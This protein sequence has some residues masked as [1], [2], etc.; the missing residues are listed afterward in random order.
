LNT[1][2]LSPWF[3][4][5]LLLTAGCGAQKGIGQAGSCQAASPD[6]G[7]SA[8]QADAGGQVPEVAEAG[9]NTVQLSRLEGQIVDI[10]IS[11]PGLALAVVVI[12][13]SNGNAVRTI[14]TTNSPSGGIPGTGAEAIGLWWDGCDDDGRPQPTGTYTTEVTATD[15]DPLHVDCAFTP[16]AATENIT[17][18]GNLDPSAQPVNFNST[19]AAATSNFNTSVVVYGS[20]GDPIQLEI[21]FSKNDAAN[22]Q[23]GDLGDWT[24]YVV[25][26]GGNLDT[27]GDG[28]TPATMGTPT[29]VAGGALRFG[30]CGVLISNVTTI[31]A[32]NPR[33]AA[34]PQPLTFN[35]GTGTAVGGT[36]V[37]GIAQ[38]RANSAVSSV[39]QDGTVALIAC[40]ATDAGADAGSSAP[41]IPDASPAPVAATTGITMRGN[42]DATAVP[43]IFDPDNV[44]TTSDFSTA[45]TVYDRLGQAIDIEIFFCMNEVGDWTYHVTTAPQN[46]ASAGDGTDLLCRLAE[47]ATGTLRFDPVG[48][49]ISN[50]TSATA[51]FVPKG[52]KI[53]QPII[54]NFGTGTASGGTG[55]DGLTQYASVSAISFISEQS[56]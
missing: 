47:I 12:R 13:D 17:I 20:L 51:S 25:T 54:F 28:T 37:D 15:G 35:F 14:K 5:S 44:Q 6:V 43:T 40:D 30:T 31:N 2:R 18:R 38:F 34:Q 10:S 46:L 52:A 32:F 33:G 49:L 50:V 55:L 45:L 29:V 27:E 8:A 4:L 9:K 16:A 26:D 22:T 41:S 24:Y 48:K 1:N 39:S 11:T 7:G 3:A 53:S 21:Y 56:I 42:L 23:P 19:V 36:G